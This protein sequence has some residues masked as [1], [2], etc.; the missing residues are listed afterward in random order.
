LTFLK[1]IEKTLGA[2]NS[3]PLNSIENFLKAFQDGFIE[4]SSTNKL[5]H[6]TVCFDR[7]QNVREYLHNVRVSTEAKFGKG[8][9]DL[10]E[11]IVLHGFKQGLNSKLYRLSIAKNIEML[12]QAVQEEER[13]V[14]LEAI[15]LQNKKLSI[16]SV[17]ESTAKP[18]WEVSPVF[19]FHVII[20]EDPEKK[21]KCT[22]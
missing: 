22:H 6:R 4:T 10:Y 13:A 5:K 16:N 18:S 2:A 1:P 17:G 14:E 9:G 12:D 21:I 8:S 15:V 7:M 11:K 19:F 3:L 20:S